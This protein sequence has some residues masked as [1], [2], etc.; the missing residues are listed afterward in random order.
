MDKNRVAMDGIVKGPHYL[1]ANGSEH[2]NQFLG[3]PY[4][5]DNGKDK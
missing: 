2:K 4:D 3:G 5:A 1:D